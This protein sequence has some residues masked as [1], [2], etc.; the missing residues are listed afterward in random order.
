[1]EHDHSADWSD[2]LRGG[3]KESEEGFNE[4]EGGALRPAWTIRAAAGCFV[5]ADR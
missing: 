2:R 3:F 4:S 5:A 1:M